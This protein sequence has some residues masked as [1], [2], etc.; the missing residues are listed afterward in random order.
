MPGRILL[1]SGMNADPR[2]FDRLSPLLPGASIVPWIE[3][4]P[5]EPLSDYARRLAVDWKTGEDTVVCGVSFGGV[6]ARELALQLHARACV[7]ISTI[8]TEHELPPRL[9]LLR[10][11]GAMGCASVLAGAGAVAAIWPRHIRQ[12]STR[13]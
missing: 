8:R 12:P 13:A 4:Q 10:P 5:R 3:P 7:L 2:I 11:L 6:V 1:L 9:R